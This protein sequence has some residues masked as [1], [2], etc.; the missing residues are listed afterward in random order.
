MILKQRKSNSKRGFTHKLD[1]RTSQRKSWGVFVS[2]NSA[3]TDERLD[4]SKRWNSEGKS[5]IDELER[6]LREQGG[7]K[8]QGSRESA[9]G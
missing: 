1:G 9:A 8:D 7:S 3:S 5:R 2:K 6:K 4:K